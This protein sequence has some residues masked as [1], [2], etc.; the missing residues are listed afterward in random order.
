MSFKQEAKLWSP[1]NKI[2]KGVEQ[3]E[4]A[5]RQIERQEQSSNTEFPLTKFATT[6]L[7]KRPRRFRAFGTWRDQILL[8]R[9][10]Y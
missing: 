5:D 3:M 4:Q 10:I 2:W 7:L 1:K 9:I 8:I 6:F